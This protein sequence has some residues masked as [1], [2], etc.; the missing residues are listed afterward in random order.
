MLRERQLEKSFPRGDSSPGDLT[1]AQAGAMETPGD[2][3]RSQDWVPSARG[4]GGIMASAWLGADVQH[5]RVGVRSGEGSRAALHL[6]RETESSFV[7]T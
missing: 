3:G 4:E 2:A 7:G 6:S 1:T 5:R